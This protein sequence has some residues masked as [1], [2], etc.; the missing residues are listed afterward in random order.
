MGSVLFR[1]ALPFIP[2]TGRAALA[3]G[4]DTRALE[5]N[6]L[7]VLDVARITADSDETFTGHPAMDD[8]E[9][10]MLGWSKCQCV[11][12]GHS[13]HLLSLHGPDALQYLVNRPSC[14]PSM[15]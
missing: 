7:P 2:A 11:S 9:L 4:P 14:T 3:P 13:N 1:S 15:R 10:V 8:A 5:Q 6:L 12:I